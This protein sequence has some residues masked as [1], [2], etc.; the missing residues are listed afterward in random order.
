[1]AKNEIQAVDT[2]AQVVA[3]QTNNELT[4][5]MGHSD[6]WKLF[7]SKMPTRRQEAILFDVYAY[8]NKNAETVSKM[9]PN[10]FMAR[11]VDCYGQGFTLQDGDCYILPFRDGKT[12]ALVAT[13]V[14]GYK[15]IVRLAMQTR[16]FKYFDCVPVIA[17]S[18]K[19][20]DYKRHVP[21]FKEDYIPNGTEETIGYF[22]YSETH[23]GMI[24]EIYHSNQYFVDFAHKKSPQNRGKDYLTGPWKD[25]FNSMCIKTGLKELGKLAPKVKNPTEQQAQFFNYVEA[26][27]E[28][29]AQLDRPQNIDED[30][31]LHSEYVC[32]VCGKEIDKKTHEQSIAKYS[33]ALCSQKCRDAYL[34][35]MGQK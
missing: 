22:A 8:V 15:G 7:M 21:I 17:E 13:L 14:P 20:F 18:I 26:E 29:T 28:M 33:V 6:S 11:V 24:R 10:E 16:L 25:D 34:S 5:F 12:G 32:S 30:G 31:V 4:E 23:D 35:D 19:S 3:T 2:E 9:K 1:M 27:E